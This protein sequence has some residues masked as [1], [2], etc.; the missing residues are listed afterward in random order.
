MGA[1][2]KEA[3]VRGGR[4]GKKIWVWKSLEK[5]DVYVVETEVVDEL[6]KKTI[7]PIIGSSTP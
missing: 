2:G 6:T 1:Q 7:T 5:G 3:N 4:K